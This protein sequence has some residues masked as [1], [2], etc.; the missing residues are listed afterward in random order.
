MD[1]MHMAVILKYEGK[2]EG[3][4]SWGKD[5]VRRFRDTRYLYE[6]QRSVPISWTVYHG[7]LERS[8]RPG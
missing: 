8:Y 5:G 2:A 3:Q 4:A 7:A 6:R 1:G